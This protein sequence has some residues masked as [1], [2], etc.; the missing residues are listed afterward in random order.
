MITAFAGYIG[1]VSGVGLLELMSK[2]LPS[3]DYFANPEINLNIALAATVL[4][5]I[6][7]A[8]AGYVPARK[9]ATVKP[10]VALRDE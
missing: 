2:V 9:A 4:L 1:L 3:H 6:A 8:I 5:V 10:V 7:G